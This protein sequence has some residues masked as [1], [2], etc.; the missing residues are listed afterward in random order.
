MTLSLI[1]STTHSSHWTANSVHTYI[2]GA[3]RNSPA[4]RS[5]PQLASRG[6]GGSR[7][8]SDR[9]AQHAE[10]L[11]LDLHDVAVFQEHR[12]LAREADTRRRARE[13]QIARLQGDDLREISEDVA[14]VED[15]LLGVTILHGLAI[16]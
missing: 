13:D 1:R 11:D 10:A 9:V 3:K 2:D 15:H 5:C 14:H 6:K 12:R 8:L 16:E 4:L 7:L